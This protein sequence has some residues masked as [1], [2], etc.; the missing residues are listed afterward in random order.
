MLAL[1]ACLSLAARATAQ[2]ESSDHAGR[3][4]DH[5]V[6]LL[7]E[8]E[9]TS[10]A[11][12]DPKIAALVK[13]SA[14]FSNYHGVAHSSLPNYLA[15]VAGSTLGVKRDRVDSPIK[16][17]SIVDRLEQKGLTWKAYAEA[18]RRVPLL[19]FASVQSNPRRSARIVNAEEFLR[20]ARA[21]KLPTYSFY[22]PSLI[23]HRSD[24]ALETESTWLEHFVQAFG[25]T[26]AS[27]QRVLL[28]V[29]WDEGGGEDARSNRV[30]AMLFGDVVK[31]GRYSRNLTHYSLLRTIE[32]NFG[33]LPLADGDA[34]ATPIP[35][36]VWR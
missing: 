32:D 8:N 33:L 12:A 18:K 14:W 7:M 19:N 31:P 27:H 3:H 22:S 20:D 16:A 28:A 23:N 26:G 29:V 21:A 13:Q 9:G 24:T 4:F 30:L 15:L 35:D 11:L 5:I 36:A 25:R 34:K 17:R 6:V 1:L 2:P 10:Q